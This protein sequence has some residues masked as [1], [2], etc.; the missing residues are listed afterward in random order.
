MNQQQMMKLR[1]LQKQ[2]QEA[3][4]ALENSEFVGTAGGVVSVKVKGTHEV[5]EVKLDKEALEDD[6]EM[7][8]D[9]IVLALN[10]AN[11]KIDEESEKAMGPFANMGLF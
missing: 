1:K 2:M 4:T 10:D 11:K 9:M 3:Q 8:E 6:I 7:V 5:L